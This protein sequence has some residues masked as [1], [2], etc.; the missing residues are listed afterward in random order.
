MK[1]DQHIRQ[2]SF[3]LLETIMAMAIMSTVILQV[4][5]TQGKVVFFSG[6]NK[7]SG[8]AMWYAKRVMA[9]VEYNATHY[10]FKDLVGGMPIKDGQFEGEKDLPFTY[11]L[12][13]NTQF[14]LP[15][16]IEFRASLTQGALA[17]IWQDN[18]GKRDPT[19][20]G[21]ILIQSGRM[22]D[23]EKKV[24]PKSHDTRVML[25]ADLVETADQH[26]LWLDTRP[27]LRE[28]AIEAKHGITL[29]A[30]LW[31]LSEEMNEDI[32]A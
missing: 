20:Q 26:K 16:S 32:A 5:A 24:E 31:Q 17:A 23:L 14:D 4:V 10:D 11:D 1:P 3:T 15:Q 25:A 6:Y 7:M 21:D 30:S 13:E 9:Q 29:R 22:M 27:S 28:V 19:F 18:D 8:E 12:M 2:A